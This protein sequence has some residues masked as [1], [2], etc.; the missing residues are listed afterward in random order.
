VHV[1]S[2]DQADAEPHEEEHD[3]VADRE[4]GQK[5]AD[6]GPCEAILRAQ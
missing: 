1:G 2:L 5:E 6:A 4:N 3:V